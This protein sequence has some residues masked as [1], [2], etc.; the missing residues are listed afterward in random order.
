[1]LRGAV[2]FE[3]SLCSKCHRYGD[4]GEA[5]GPDLTSIAKRFTRKEILQSLLYPSHVISSQYVAKTL[6]LTD[7]RQLSG[8]VAPG[9]EG[10][11]VVLK[12]DGEKVSVPEQEID[13]VHPSNVSAMPVAL[14]DE[15]SL[16]QIADLFAY[17]NS[18]PS[19]GVALRVE[20]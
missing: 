5:M 6:L 11:Q 18:P 8:I 13:E 20:D 9:P 4:H 19:Q 1:M 3:K 12:S 16:E 15:L 17:L 2:V 7:G 14:L 10:E